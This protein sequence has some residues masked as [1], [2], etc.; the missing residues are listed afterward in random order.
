MNALTGHE[1]KILRL[2]IIWFVSM[3]L[4][5]IAISV[6]FY[7][8]YRDRK[9]YNCESHGHSFEARYQTV[10]ATAEE[11]KVIG[12]TFGWS[13]DKKQALR[14]LEKKVYICEVCEYCG[15]VIHSSKQT[16]S[17]K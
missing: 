14:D 10:P 4:S 3:A 15:D 2:L 13:S 11:I 17:Q 16:L 12:N 8:L 5:V 7:T 1:K 6:S 9:E